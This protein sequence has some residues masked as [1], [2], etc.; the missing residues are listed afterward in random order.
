MLH[1]Q[2][3]NWGSFGANKT[4]LIRL[5]NEAARTPK[6]YETE[7]IIVYSKHNFK[8]SGLVATFMCSG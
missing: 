5:K 6:Y 1:I 4:F 8:Y 2:S 7:T 3:F